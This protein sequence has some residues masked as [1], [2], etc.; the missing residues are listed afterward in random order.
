MGEEKE[1]VRLEDGELRYDKDEYE[2]DA[3]GEKIPKLPEK[4]WGGHP[5]TF[6]L[7]KYA[8]STFKIGSPVFDLIDAG[9]QDHCPVFVYR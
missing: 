5:P 2:E 6:L 7:N 8:K 9:G 4:G 3:N 1:S